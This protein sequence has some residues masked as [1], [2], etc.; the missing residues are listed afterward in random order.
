[1]YAVIGGPIGAK[2]GGVRR[3]VVAR[4]ATALLVCLGVAALGPG[5]PADAQAPDPPPGVVPALREWSPGPG[6]FRLGAAS[7]I[8][9]DAGCAGRRGAA[10]ARRP[11]RGDRLQ[12]AG[13]GQGRGPKDGDLFLSAAAA[14]RRAGSEG[15]V[16]EIGDRVDHC[17]AA[18]PASSTERRRVLQM[19]RSR[20]GQRTLPRGEAR[21][22][23]RFRERGYMLDAGRKYWSPDYVVQT[24]REMAY[25]KLNTLQLHLSDNN[26]FRL[27]SDRFPYLAAP[28]AYTKADIRRFEAAARNYHVTIIPE[29]EMPAHA[30]AILAVRP[31]LGLDCRTFGTTLDVTRR[32]VRDFTRALIDE[33]APLFSGPEFHIASDEYPG[34][35]HQEDCE[36]LVRYAE[37]R[38][39]G[40]TADVF[41]DFINEMNSGRPL[42][43]QADGDLELVGRRPGPHDRP[44]HEHQGRDVDHRGDRR[45]SRPAW[46]RPAALPRPG[47]RGG[48]LA[49]RQAVRHT[50]VAAAARPQVPLRG[51]GAARAPAA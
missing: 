42:A 21:D 44:G 20:P 16:L 30:G 41:V 46:V 47:L 7:R 28:E 19:L 2:P 12:P 34:R 3:D 23:P 35:L 36:P 37:E 25:L 27:V 15:Y 24:I 11:G 51:V 48:R 17:A 18:T 38:G 4:F 45:R 9:V 43:W 49:Q 5:S 26:A 50:G 31:D 6:A 39:F 8:V 13:G 14:P 32:E 33:F 10:V 22:W 29:I 1:M 40:S